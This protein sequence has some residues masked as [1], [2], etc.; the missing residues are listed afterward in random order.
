MSGGLGVDD[1]LEEMSL[2]K[3]KVVGGGVNALI[4][5]ST[6]ARK[7]KENHKS[8]RKM[9][10]CSSYRGINL[11]FLLINNW[12]VELGMLSVCLVILRC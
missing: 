1:V 3:D 8:S 2:H 9:N 11:L 4:M 6:Y 10:G 5:K 7:V 12:V